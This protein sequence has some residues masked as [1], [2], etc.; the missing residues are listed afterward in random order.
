MT[1]LA[2]A[3]DEAGCDDTDILA[4]CRKPAPHVRD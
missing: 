4:H 2:D 3:L 1:I